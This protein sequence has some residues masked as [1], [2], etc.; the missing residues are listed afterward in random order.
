[1]FGDATMDRR[2][3]LRG[4][5]ASFIALCAAAPS[6]YGAEG[7]MTPAL[8][9]QWRRNWKWMEGLA[10]KRG[11]DVRR[12]TIDSPA[13][14]AALAIIELRHG[15]AC[16]AQ[17]RK[18]LT[19]YSARVSF[20]WV[21]PPHLRPAEKMQIP[22][23]SGLSLS[24]WDL[25]EIDEYAIPNFLNWRRRLRNVATSEEPNRPEMWEK[26]FPIA[27]LVN[28]DMVTIDVSDPREPCPVRYFS[29]QLEGLHGKAIAPDFISF[30]TVYSALG[31]PGAEDVDWFS[32][33]PSS[34]GDKHY[35]S[36]E[37]DGAKAW[38]AWLAKD[39][40]SVAPD[41]PPLAVVE[42]TPD[43]RALLVAARA[44]S[45][46]GVTAALAGGAKI[47]CVPN[48]DWLL[49]ND[50]YNRPQEFETATIFAVRNNNIP[51]LEMLLARGATLNTRLLVMTVA[52][53]QSS[54]EMFRWLIA[55]GA[56]VNGWR[57]D[58]YW[59]SHM[60]VERRGYATEAR[61]AEQVKRWIPLG[62][63]R[64]QAEWLSCKPV[65]AETY[66]AMLDALLDAGADPDARW[67]N[68]L[69]MLMRGSVAVAERL[70]K[71]GAKIDLRSAAGFM[72][73][74]LA[75]SPEKVRLL[76]AHG[77]DINAR[78]AA[79][80][81]DSGSF[82]YTPL[83]GSLQSQSW[84]PAPQ[85]IAALLEFGAD[86]KIRDA[87][88]RSTLAYCRTLEDFKKMQ[89]YGLDATERLP[90]GGTLLHNL[91]APAGALPGA[92][93]QNEF[94]DYLLSLGID[95][96]AADDTG[97]TALHL[98][99]SDERIQAAQLKFF[100]DRGANPSIKDKSGNAPS[101]LSRNRTRARATCCDDL[102]RREE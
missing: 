101:T 19:E 57:D 31:C 85:L 67:D 14:S 35:L 53:E 17:L 74:H 56:R 84:R 47:D 27:T 23:G 79:P 91:V 60:L 51:L 4:G 1:M 62:A 29:H 8:W 24:V 55:H 50:F 49:D 90:G 34:D 46:G 76:V 83:Q 22:S 63:S 52:A 87:E 102:S 12:L 89:S 80:N 82:S 75:E 26:Q 48:L 97:Q 99:A 78:A 81:A 18:L 45:S 2:R 98:L 37:G 71:H 42:T 7:R 3:L 59:P 72:A 11:W 40:V 5:G 65:D 58:R 33:I 66:Y 43:D 96:N 13:D 69:T 77:A 6:A 73:I 94:F 36:S 15:L 86:P 64:A 92:P 30:M 88:G 9:A 16:P 28:G 21:I 93:S 68:G 44:N 41:E 10:L 61:C 95:I 100:L 25:A 39:P 20:H 54:L 32:F 70:L 38:F